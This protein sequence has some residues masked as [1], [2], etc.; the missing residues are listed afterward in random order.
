MVSVGLVL[1]LVAIIVSAIMA[2]I[3]NQWN[4]PVWWALLAIWAVLFFSVKSPWG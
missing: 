4:S 2:G 3:Y 1:T